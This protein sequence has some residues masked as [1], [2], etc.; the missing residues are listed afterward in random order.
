MIMRLA[1][2]CLFPAILAQ[3]ALPGVPARAQAFPIDP[4]TASTTQGDGL[5]DAGRTADA[6]SGEI[7][8]RQDAQEAVPFIA[9]TAR[10]S[11]RVPNRLQTRL[12]NRIDRTYRGDVDAS[13][14]YEQTQEAVRN[15]GRGR[16]R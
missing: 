11:N 10:I 7:G 9:P 6:G 14:S 15:T 5:R 1:S 4:A 3:L 16:P 13:S 12:Q 8:Q 2:I